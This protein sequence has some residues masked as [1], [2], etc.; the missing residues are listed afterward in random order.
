MPVRGR[1]PEVR[2]SDIRSQPPLSR[3]RRAK[4]VRVSLSIPPLFHVSIEARR[5]RCTVTTTNRESRRRSPE[6]QR[7]Q[8]FSQLALMHR[9]RLTMHKSI[10]ESLRS[11][12]SRGGHCF[13]VR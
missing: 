4:E 6:F 10:Q 7:E 5:A 13:S 2:K 1:R 12:R 11:L 8:I 3:L 9:K